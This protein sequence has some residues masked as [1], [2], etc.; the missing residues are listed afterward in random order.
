MNKE[1]KTPLCPLCGVRE[2]EF[3]GEPPLS[4]E[5]ENNFFGSC[6][7]CSSLVG[8][9]DHTHTYYGSPAQVKAGTVKAGH[10]WRTTVSLVPIMEN[11]THVGFRCT[12]HELCGWEQRFTAADMEPCPVEHVDRY[13]IKHPPTYKVMCE[14]SHPDHK[15]ERGEIDG[16][17]GYITE[18][19]RAVERQRSDA[20]NWGPGH[21]VARA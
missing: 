19:G 4:E 14:R 7:E 21:Y 17:H 15:R 12:Q 13:G 5:W 2:R 1:R 9:R 20:E 8:Y 10:S 16:P 6:A 11:G 3:D 18:H